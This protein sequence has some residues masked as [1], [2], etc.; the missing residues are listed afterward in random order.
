[1]AKFLYSFEFSSVDTS[2]NRAFPTYPQGK[3]SY[4]QLW[5]DLVSE[6]V[7]ATIAVIY[8]M[9]MYISDL[10]PMG[11]W[12]RSTTYPSPL[13]RMGYLSSSHR[14]LHFGHCC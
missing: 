5:G 4:R 1:M 10:S 9:G 3:V 2:F 11:F 7:M 13:I 6:V 12:P 14:D 8:M